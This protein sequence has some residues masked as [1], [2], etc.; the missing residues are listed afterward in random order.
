MA[1]ARAILRLAAGRKEDR[2]THNFPIATAQAPCR[3][4]RVHQNA[5]VLCGTAGSFVLSSR[6]V[7]LGTM[8][9][10]HGWKNMRC[11]AF[12]AGGDP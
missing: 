7:A 12:L 8:T 4:A 2:M 11:R 3:T 6:A 10:D 1:R 5:P 9:R